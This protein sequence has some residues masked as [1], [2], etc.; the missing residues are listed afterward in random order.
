MWSHQDHQRY[1]QAN[2]SQL[3]QQIDTQQQA[4]S[5]LTMMHTKN[6]QQQQLSQQHQSALELTMMPANNLIVSQGIG[7]H[8]NA[9]RES[10]PSSSSRASRNL[11]EKQRR[12]NLNTNISLMASLV[13]SIASSSK[14]YDKIS[15][16][17]LTAAYLRSNLTIGPGSPGFLPAEF[18]DISL[19]EN[20]I[21]SFDGNGGFFFVVTI[22]GSIVYI[23]PRVE[24]PLGYTPNEMMG[25]SLYSYIHPE[26]HGELAK[27]LTPDESFS[28]KELTYDQDSNSS[29][30]LRNHLPKG[31]NFK[32]QRRNFYI[33]IA[34]RTNSRGEH[35]QFKCFQ[36]SGILRL[37]DFI[38]KKKNLDQHNPTNNDIIFAG[39]ARVVQKRITELSLYEA[40]K[41]E[42]KTRHLVDG[43][44][45]YS[46]HRIAFVAGYMSEEVAGANAFS[47]MHKEDV[48]WAIMALRQMYDRR[49]KFG[50]SCY[51]LLSKRGEFIYLR[52][53]GFLEFHQ[54]TGT[55]ESFV[56]IN[57]LVE[58]EEG[59][60]L[61]KELKN[62]FSAT[63]SPSNALTDETV[64][65]S[66]LSPSVE[67][68]TQ[69]E[70]AISHLISNLNSP[71]AVGE[72]SP[73]PSVSD[74]PSKPPKSC[75][76]FP[77]NNKLNKKSSEA[78]TKKHK[79]IK[80]EPSLS[81]DCSPNNSEGFDNHSNHSSQ[82]QTIFTSLSTPDNTSINNCQ[83]VTNNI[84]DLLSKKHT[85]DEDSNLHC[86]QSNDSNYSLQSQNYYESLN[87]NS[88][89]NIS[90]ENGLKLGQA[91]KK[92]I[93]PIK[94]YNHGNNHDNLVNSTPISIKSENMNGQEHQGIKR[95]VEEEKSPVLDKK[96]RHNGFAEK[97]ELEDLNLQAIMKANP[98][99]L[100]VLDELDQVID[101]GKDLE[102]N[103]QN[104]PN[105]QVEQTLRETYLH[106]E[107]RISYQ[108]IQLN[109]LGLVFEN[110]DLSTEREDFDQLQAEHQI[111]KEMIKT[112]QEDHES[113]HMHN[114]HDLD[115]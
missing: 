99:I 75:H 24:G 45:I 23:S 50:T 14:R 77:V 87:L 19:E 115:V 109:E 6:L 98:N 84:S 79:R 7:H 38:K 26:D 89:N 73:P 18:N 113:L 27:A 78:P 63:V 74:L 92:K 55:F 91:S 86:N 97:D 72:Q 42:Y 65:Q 67:D 51:R 60:N 83:L 11:A 69:L 34:Q 59:E 88:V 108:G 15:I 114:V 112:L 94:N 30:G 25:K 95:S 76:Q 81:F 3:P 54:E 104:F 43:R 80:H 64:I 4:A 37:A 48:M 106:L 32:E 57:T 2:V 70:D 20:F 105:D 9:S 56:C 111:Q 28:M 110:S 85:H 10:T 22:S 102:T 96:Q 62:R 103:L 12:D 61:I 8:R 49:E 52:T 66:Q 17:R 47:Y 90:N 46:D 41:L 101:T 5:Q 71:P 82:S 16:L 44:I 36:I 100:K 40:N 53:H 107:N 58:K 68:P 93:S 31:K 29:D 21:D 33:K 35:T 39:V 1:Q 13:P